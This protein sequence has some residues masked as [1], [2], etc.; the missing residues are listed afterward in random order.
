MVITHNLLIE[1]Y[2][3][4]KSSHG[5][6]TPEKF[7]DAIGGKWYVYTSNIVGVERYGVF[8]KK[9]QISRID[10]DMSEPISMDSIVNEFGD[11]SQAFNHY[12]GVHVYSW[13]PSLSGFVSMYVEDPCRDYSQI[14]ELTTI[15]LER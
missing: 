14:K 3:E 5:V 13:N 12:D 8:L 6:L 2:E 9:N 15:T 4:A 11:Y 1:T 10:I 7:W